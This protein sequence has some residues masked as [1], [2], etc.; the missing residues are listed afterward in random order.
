M[1]AFLF[2]LVQTPGLSYEK[3]NFPLPAITLS[4]GL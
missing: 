4:Y 1:Q 3:I 2:I